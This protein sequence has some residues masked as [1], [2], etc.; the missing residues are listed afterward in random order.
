MTI[1]LKKNLCAMLMGSV[2]LLATPFATATGMQ[3]E[4]SVVILYEA[5]GETSINVKNTDGAPA[6]L[7]STIENIPEDTE[8]LVILT[9]PVTRVE[10]GE[11]QL[12]RFLRQG[13][14]PSKTQRLKRVIF[15]GIAQ[16]RNAEGKAT[17][18]V[19]VRQNLP[20]IIHPKGL[21]RNREPWKLL[22]WDIKDGKLV[23]VNDSAYVVRMA[24]ELELKP[25]GKMSALPRSYVLPGETLTIALDPQAIHSSSV[26]IGPATVYG[27]AVDN[28]DAPIGNATAR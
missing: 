1:Q 2:A 10:A 25:S 7:Y 4:T 3:P 20:L 17:V 28:Y 26:T 15:E 24:Q 14:E 12:V 16:K 23:V 22:K 18:G 13:G 27:Y 6:L 11:T 21:E 9:P 8:S 19:S 5:E